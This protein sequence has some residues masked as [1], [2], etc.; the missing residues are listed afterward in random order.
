MNLFDTSRKGTKL[1]NGKNSE[2]SISLQE[3]NQNE[4]REKWKNL[5]EKKKLLEIEERH[6]DLEETKEK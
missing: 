2:T 4:N 5:S 1:K 3:K 6:V